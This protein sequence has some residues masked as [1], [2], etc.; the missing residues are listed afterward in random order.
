ML[1]KTN[2]QKIQRQIKEAA[3]RGKH[4]S[5]KT[6]HL[7]AVT[8][9]VSVDLAQEVLNSGIF[10][11]AE[12]RPETLFEKQEKLQDDQMKW[13]Y[14]GSLQTRKVKQV[15]NDIDYFHALDRLSLAQEIH[16]RA[17]SPVACFIQV[18]IAGEAQKH[19][20]APNKLEDFV[21]ALKDY[22]NVR[23]IGLMTMAPYTT[24]ENVLRETFSGLRK[25]QQY[26]KELDLPYAP[27]EELSMGMSQDYQIAVEEGATFVRIGTALF[28]SL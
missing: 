1:I 11:L 9:A 27:C 6:V 3:V 2:I 28:E 23:V 4:A 13:H 17:K 20:L 7:I 24:D 8:K 12:N 16:K 18:N 19:G 14:I 22:P 21:R 5:S 10:D 25:W 26:I 15:I